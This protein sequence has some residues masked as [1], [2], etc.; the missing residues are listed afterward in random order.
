MTL[1]HGARG[2]LD[3]LRVT[4]A[5][6]IIGSGNLHHERRLIGEYPRGGNRKAVR[7]RAVAAPGEGER[8]V[9]ET[10]RR[11]IHVRSY[12]VTDVVSVIGLAQRRRIPCV[13]VS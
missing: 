9:F 2:L 11:V 8:A 7:D 5:T 12:I 4:A 1:Q 13:V 3:R 10:R 6:C